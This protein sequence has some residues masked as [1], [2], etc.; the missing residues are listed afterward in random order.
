[1][2]ALLENGIW[3]LVDFFKGT[4]IIDNKW[5]Y[6]IKTESNGEIEYYK[7]CLIAPGFRQQKGIDYQEVFAP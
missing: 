2:N 1:M 5:V 3:E 6:T 4:Q 7:A